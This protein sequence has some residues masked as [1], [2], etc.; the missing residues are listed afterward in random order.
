MIGRAFTDCAAE[1]TQE[2]APIRPLLGREAENQQENKQVNKKD[3]TAEKTLDRLPGG[4]VPAEP[5]PQRAT[6]SSHRR[7]GRTARHPAWYALVSESNKK[8]LR[9]QQSLTLRTIVKAPRFVRNATISRD[10][11]VES[12]DDFVQCL[13][14]NMF[15]RAS[16]SQHDHLRAL[17]PYHRRPPDGYGLPRDLVAPTDPPDAAT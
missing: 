9:A 4:F 15:E 16:K 8:R 17:A 13:S 11:G 1:P 5:S 6:H 10:L 2:A 14:T 7:T 3:K 12:V